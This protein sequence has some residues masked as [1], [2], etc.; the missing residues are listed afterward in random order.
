M[1]LTM[2]TTGERES[3]RDL[4]IHDMS[5]TRLLRLGKCTNQTAQH[6]GTTTTTTPNK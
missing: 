4:T 6:T 2:H 1:L 5:Q 3:E